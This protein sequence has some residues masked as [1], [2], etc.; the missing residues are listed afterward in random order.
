MKKLPGEY[1]RSLWRPFFEMES[2]LVIYNVLNIVVAITIWAVFY[3]YLGTVQAL[4]ASQMHLTLHISLGA[5]VFFGRNVVTDIFSGRALKKDDI[6]TIFLCVVS[7]TLVLPIVPVLQTG[8]SLWLEDL[9]ADARTKNHDC[10]LFD[11]FDLDDLMDFAK[12][13]LTFLFLIVC[14]FVKNP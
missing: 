10:I 7:I 11:F 2:M 12:A 9:P 3:F 6:L 5:I 8:K 4:Q 13:L 1:V 14:T